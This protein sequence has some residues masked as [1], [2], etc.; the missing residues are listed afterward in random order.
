MNIT[1]ED[2]VVS[3]IVEENNDSPSIVKVEDWKDLSDEEL[4]KSIKNS[5]QQEIGEF[6]V[7]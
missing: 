3:Q 5:N 4:N 7:L 2:E 6:Y 1:E